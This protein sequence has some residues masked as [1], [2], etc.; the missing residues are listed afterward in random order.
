MTSKVQS[1]IC[2]W[3]VNYFIE[4]ALCQKLRKYLQCLFHGYKA[5]TIIINIDGSLEIIVTKF[6]CVCLRSNIL[7]DEHNNVFQTCFVSKTAKISSMSAITSSGRSMLLFPHFKISTM[8]QNSGY[9]M[10][11]F[12][13]RLRMERISFIFFGV[14]FSPRYPKAL[15]T[16]LTWISDAP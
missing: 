15:L 11:D 5:F 6:D 12:S 9:R 8:S 10:F 14:A 13:S 7:S 1:Y 16:S 2:K 3:Q 4:P